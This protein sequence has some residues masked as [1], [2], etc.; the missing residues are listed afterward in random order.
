M[1]NSETMRELI[2]AASPV[3]LSGLLKVIVKELSSDYGEPGNCHY[4][5]SSTEDKKICV[6]AS[7]P[8]KSLRPTTSG[9]LD[10][11]KATSVGLLSISSKEPFL[12]NIQQIRSEYT[13]TL[14]YGVF[15][16]EGL[17]LHKA[18]LNNLKADPNIRFIGYQH[19]G[20]GDEGQIY[21]TRDSFEKH[22]PYLFK[23]LTYDAIYDIIKDLKS[24]KA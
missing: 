6:K 11:L 2:I 14:W 5:F 21:I 10:Y 1:S 18:T 24:P 15:F 19:T 13:D 17:Y 7:R 20:N 12:C 3:K 4:H 22:A 9:Y 23:V 8:L 16:H